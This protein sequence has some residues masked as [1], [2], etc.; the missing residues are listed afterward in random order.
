M[1]KYVLKEDPTELYDYI[2]IMLDN[3][4]LDKELKNIHEMIKKNNGTI[5]IDRILITGNNSNRF[6]VYQ[7]KNKNIDLKHSKM[8]DLNS[9][10]MKSNSKIS[11]FV[12]EILKKFPNEL[13]GSVLTK[14]EKEF[15][16]HSG[17]NRV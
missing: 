10:F 5:I 12:F 7:I 4:S 1:K 17:K 14:K 8:V 15:I 3:I 9:A 16:Y 11:D 6:I 13:F 2:L